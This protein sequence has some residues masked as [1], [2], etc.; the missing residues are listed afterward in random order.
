MNT[1]TLTDRKPHSL[2]TWIAGLM[3]GAVATTNFIVTIA[4][5]SGFVGHATPDS[6]DP[7]LTATTLV[8]ASAGA[9]FGAWYMARRAK[10]AW[11]KTFYGVLLLLVAAKLIWDIL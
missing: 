7:A 10:P 6:L 5:I 9:Q 2:N 1:S 11:V 3:L 8:A 4:S